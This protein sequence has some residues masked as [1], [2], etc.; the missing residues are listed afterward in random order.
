MLSS[1]ESDSSDFRSDSVGWGCQSHLRT[2]TLLW[3]RLGLSLYGQVS[4]VHWTCL[5]C[6]LPFFVY[7]GLLL[8]TLSFVVC[9]SLTLPFLKWYSLCCSRI[10][11]LPSTLGFTGSTHSTEICTGKGPSLV[12]SGPPN[13]NHC[14]GKMQQWPSG[15]LLELQRSQ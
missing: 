4:S 5:Y 13:I 11:S 7:Q 3:S 12:P 10:R 8:S 1:G 2:Q 15:T 14:A 6:Q 9:G